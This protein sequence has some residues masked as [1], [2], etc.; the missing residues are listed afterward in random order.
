MAIFLQKN[1]VMDSYLAKAQM[2][3]IAKSMNTYEDFSGDLVEGGVTNLFNNTI[4]ETLTTEELYEWLSNP[5]K[6]WN[7]IQSYMAYLYYAN[8]NV[9]QLYT[10]IKTLF[11]LKYTIESFEKSESSNEKNTQTLHKTLRKVKHKELTRDLLV[12]SCVNGTVVC[13]WLGDKKNPYLHIFDKTNYVFPKYRRNGEWV[14]VIDLAMFDDMDEEAE[15]PIWFETLKGI[16]TESDYEKYQSNNSDDTLRYIELPQE[17][18]KVIRINTLFR[19][20]R[21]GLPMGTQYLEDLIHKKSFRELETAIV[22]KAVRSIATLTIGTKETPYLNI[23]KKVRTNVANGA[24]NSLQQSVTS[25]G[26]PL[27][28]LPEWA[29]LELA[30]L[31]GFAGLGKDKYEAIDNDTSIDSGLPTPMFTGK[32]G[33]SASMKYAYNFLYRRIAEILEQVEDVYNKLFFFVLGK[34]SDN[35]WMEYNKEIPLDAKEILAT[36]KGL[37]AE[38][39][40]VKPIVDML[41]NI[42]YEDYISQTL[43]EQETLDLYSKIKPPSTSYTQTGGSDDD[44]KAGAKPKDETEL[45]DEGIKTRDGG[46]NEE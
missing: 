17:T 19:N 14:A 16:V 7:N 4:T 32:D 15:R 31:D 27:V 20:Q 5:D 33:S 37:H 24:Y 40:A 42:N 2:D 25:N 18:T 23:N 41:P 34:K 9:Y 6:Y 38:G 8:G 21:I 35:Y 3:N 36:L 28:V 46:K 29:K 43:F 30:T 26:T 22:K 11:D 12:Q 45:S 39:F 44:S 13:T 1:Q 10:I